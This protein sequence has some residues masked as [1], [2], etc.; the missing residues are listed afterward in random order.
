MVLRGWKECGGVYVFP[1]SN[2]GQSDYIIRHLAA[3]HTPRKKILA[4]GRWANSGSFLLVGQIKIYL[5]VEAGVSF[6][7]CNDTVRGSK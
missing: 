4:D 3:P 6:V 2:L 1:E 7:S 5:S